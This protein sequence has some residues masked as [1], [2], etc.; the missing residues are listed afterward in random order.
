M[1]IGSLYGEMYSIHHLIVSLNFIGTICTLM[2]SKCIKYKYI[3]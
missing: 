1:K 3:S 2:L